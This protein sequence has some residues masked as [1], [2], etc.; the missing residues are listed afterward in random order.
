MVA[1][2]GPGWRAQVAQHV[3]TSP[4]SGPRRKQLLQSWLTRTCLINE[5]ARPVLRVGRSFAR[6]ILCGL[7]VLLADTTFSSKASAESCLG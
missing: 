4:T 6:R 3:T 2:R 7:L 5:A 1:N